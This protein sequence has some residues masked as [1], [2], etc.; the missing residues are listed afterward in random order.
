MF[1]PPCAEAVLPPVLSPN[2]MKQVRGAGADAFVLHRTGQVS[3]ICFPL[4]ARR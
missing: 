3:V 4:E 2:Q 1:D